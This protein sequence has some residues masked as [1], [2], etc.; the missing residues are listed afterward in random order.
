MKGRREGYR[1]SAIAGCAALGMAMTASPASAVDYNFG[2]TT[3]SIDSIASVGATIRASGQECLYVAV[4]NG[5]CRDFNGN[6]ANINTD[7]GNINFDQWDVVSSPVKI[8]TDFELR[9][10]NWG[11]FARARAY[12]DYAVYEEAGQNSTQYGQR[13]LTDNLRGDDARNS[14]RGLD[15]LDAFVFT[16]FDLGTIPT[17]LRAGKQVINWGESLAI[18]GGINQFN[19]IDVA[20]IRT[21]GAELR[22]A[23]LPEESLY[24][25]LA[26]P[27]DLSFEAFYAFNWRQTELDAAG[28]FFAS[29]DI[30][31][32]GGRYVNT[33]VPEQPPAGSPENA[34]TIYKGEGDLPDDQG[35]F[36][37]KL[38][39]WA[40]W[41]NDGTELS[42]YF[43]NYHSKLPYLEYSNGAPAAVDGSLCAPAPSCGLPGQYYRDAYPENIKYVGVSF[44]TTVAG[45]SIAGETLYSWNMP[46]GISSGETLGARWIDNATGGAAGAAVLPYD[47]TPGAF[48]KGY[49]REDVINGQLSSI[50]MLN[51]SSGVTRFF[52]ADSTVL[53]S[54]IGFQYLPSISDARLSVTS[55][56]R[57]SEIT[58]PNPAVQFPLYQNPNQQLIHA[59]T[60]STG[61]RLIGVLTYNNVLN[62]PWSL[63]PT[64]QWQHDVKG[65]SAGTI[66][67]GFIDRRKTVTLGVTADLQNTWRANVS[68]TNSFGNEFQNYTQ[69]RDFISAS[70]SY[71]F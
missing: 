50:T 47:M 8:V 41:L 15:L 16:N 43:V 36:G 60:F 66:G 4:V 35:Q 62:T 64:I 67:P 44:A 18:Q 29:N 26:L 68:Y 13:P 59:D 5:G 27:A 54:N 55:G 32:P 28:T 20:A 63:S 70:L 69:D 37:A 57:G 38:G 42:A 61:Y 10:K 30:F 11:A 46:L 58:H 21:P 34:G 17:S 12:Y 19:A 6:S 22:E 56:G 23:L 52:D 1:L 7:D 9:W 31:G 3:L 33:A 45:T 48:P 39:Y 14:A 53:I 24:V 49:F 51:P 25:N 65:N 40:G 2:D 71:A